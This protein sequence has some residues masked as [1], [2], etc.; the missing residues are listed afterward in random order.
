[1]K[2][3]SFVWNFVET[4]I[5]CC[6]PRF[7]LILTAKFH[8]LFVMEPEI[9][10]RPETGVGVG[11]FGKAESDSG[12]G[13]GNFGKVGVGVETDLLPPTRQPWQA[14][15]YFSPNSLVFQT[16]CTATLSPLKT[17]THRHDQFLFLLFIASMLCVVQKSYRRVKQVVHPLTVPGRALQ[18]PPRMHLIDNSSQVFFLYYVIREWLAKILLHSHDPEWE[19][20]WDDIF[21]GLSKPER[22]I[23]QWCEVVD[24]EAEQD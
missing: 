19:M 9:L 3:Y 11:K 21:F 13:V 23:F 4:E 18:I 20:P 8:S 10:E 22:Q 15:V 1:M 14:V 17:T 24:C 12:V 5:S 2:W 7:L 6:A 16:W